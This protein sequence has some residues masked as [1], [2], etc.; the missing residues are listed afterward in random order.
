[1]GPVVENPQK[2][3]YCHNGENYPANLPFIIVPKYVATGFEW[4]DEPQKGGI[5]SSRN[6]KS[7]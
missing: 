6:N 4:V 3:I 2:E 1:M 5:W 7:N